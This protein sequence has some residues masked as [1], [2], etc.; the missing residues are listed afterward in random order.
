MG[1]TV[2]IKMQDP[3]YL[4]WHGRMRRCL[5]LAVSPCYAVIWDFHRSTGT[6]GGTP[7]FTASPWVCRAG[8]PACQS[9]T[10]DDSQPPP[11]FLSP[12]ITTEDHSSLNPHCSAHVVPAG[13]THASEIFDGDPTL[14]WITQQI[15]NCWTCNRMTVDFVW[16]VGFHLSPC[17]QDGFTI[18]FLSLM[19][20][21]APLPEHIKVA[22]AGTHVWCPSVSQHAAQ[23]RPVSDS[24]V[25]VFLHCGLALESTSI[26]CAVAGQLGSCSIINGTIV[27]PTPLLPRGL[28]PEFKRSNE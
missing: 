11:P 5:F 2:S 28:R 16:R 12:L 24:P 7:I 27:I 10:V 25:P 18:C 17:H 1:N 4:E 20:K 14:G 9:G 23:H 19:H 8:A 13:G 6:G 22:S 21:P 26:M 15:D 3:G